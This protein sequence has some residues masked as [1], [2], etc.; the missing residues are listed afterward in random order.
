M[1]QASFAPTIRR[2]EVTALDDV[3]PRAEIAAWKGWDSGRVRDARILISNDAF[4]TPRDEVDMAARLILDAVE[5]A[6]VAEMS[7]YWCLDVMGIQ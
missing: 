3:A 7:S 4:L 2:H 6:L 1:R 5:E